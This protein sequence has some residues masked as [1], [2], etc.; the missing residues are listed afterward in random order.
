VT[1][2]ATPAPAGQAPRPR[3]SVFHAFVRGLGE[4][5]ITLGVL[6][7]LLVVYQLYW[8]NV[9][10]NRAQG[11]LKDELRKEWSAPVEQVKTKPIPGKAL[12]LMYFERL[13][14]KW[15]KPIVEGVD[16]D[17]LAKGVGHFP[18]NALPGEVGN[19]A[20]A[21]HRTTHGEPFK[22]LDKVRKGDRLVVETRDR[23]Y[24][25]VIDTNFRLVDPNNGS[26]V[27]AVPEKAGVKP[28]EK[29][30]TLV[31]CNPRWGSS[32]RLIYYGHLE[33]SV[34]KQEGKF[35]AALTYMYGDQD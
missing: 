15:V 5:M 17:D 8:T 23:W 21:A 28:T 11:E 6:M 27:W 34:K 16:L 25:Y 22:D 30:I 1:A 3:K 32:T 7:L 33:S 13:G 26:V 24:V 31:T 12:G 4:L 18:K 29:L 10:A 2:I 20:L 9:E 19:F 35:P 14:K